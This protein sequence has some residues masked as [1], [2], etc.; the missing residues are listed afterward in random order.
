MT[1]VTETVYKEKERVPS[2]QVPVSRQ[3]GAWLSLAALH[4]NC[5]LSSYCCHTPASKWGTSTPQQAHP[6][7][8]RCT[9]CP[10]RVQWHR[11]LTAWFQL[12]TNSSFPPFLQPP[13]PLLHINFLQ[14]LFFH[15]THYRFY[16]CLPTWSVALG[17][18]LCAHFTQ[19]Y[20][21]PWRC[22]GD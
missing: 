11:F 19:A 12:Q 18:S 1:I 16:V 14:S 21:W 13:P 4:M 20:T 17:K 15:V 2:S 6:S 10:Q 5:S 9:V 8:S 7:A 22:A 3:G